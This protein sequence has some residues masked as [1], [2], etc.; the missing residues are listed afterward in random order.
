M[1]SPDLIETVVNRGLIEFYCK[2]GKKRKAQVKNSEGGVSVR[3]LGGHRKGVFVAFPVDPT[4]DEIKAPKS[5]GVGF[6]LC[7]TKAGDEFDAMLAIR[8][9]AFRAVCEKP[10]V[11]PPSMKRRMMKFINRANRY[12]QDANIVTKLVFEELKNENTQE[13]SSEVEAAD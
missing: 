7:N 11:V 5:I 2:G 8:I 9:A 3:W 10:M 12:F 13:A 6:A 1:Y 4:V